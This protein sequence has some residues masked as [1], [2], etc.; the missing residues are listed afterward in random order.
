MGFGELPDGF[1]EL[2]DGLNLP[3]G[4]QL[5]AAG[6]A[7]EVLLGLM[8]IVGPFDVVNAIVAH[9]AGAAHH[10]V[11][12]CTNPECPYGVD[13]E[14]AYDHVF[15]GLTR[16]IDQA[17]EALRDGFLTKVESDRFESEVTAYLDTIEVADEADIEAGDTVEVPLVPGADADEVVKLINSIIDDGLGD[18]A[19]DPD[20]A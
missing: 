20:A 10:H 17:K 1:P 12:E 6:S 7:A 13:P 9:A 18:I 11:M 5:A 3:E 2:P 4:V 16:A 15:E 14:M 8:D 19:P